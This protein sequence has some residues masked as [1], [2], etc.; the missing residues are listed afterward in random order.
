[1]SDSFKRAPRT[2]IEHEVEFNHEITGRLTLITRDISDTGVFI[3]LEPEQHPPI[4]TEAKV[5][6]KNNFADGEAP[7]SLRCKVV[8]QTSKGIGLQFIL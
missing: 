8:R 7:P 1:M 4:G 2:P 3:R 5:R 6:L